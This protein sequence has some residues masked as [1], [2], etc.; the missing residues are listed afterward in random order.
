VN[1]TLL[2]NGIFPSNDVNELQN[3]E[4]LIMRKTGPATNR[5]LLYTYQ[6]V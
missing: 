5:D 1:I 4:I 6:T 2:N 3:E